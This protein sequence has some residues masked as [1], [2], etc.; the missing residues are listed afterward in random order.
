[1]NSFVE[2]CI[3]QVKP[4]KVG[5]FE[6]LVREMEVFQKEF[7]GTIDIKYMKRTHTLDGTE[8]LKTGEP[9]KKLERIIKSVKYV[10][11]WELRDCIVHGNATMK[12]FQRYGKDFNRLLVMPAD[13]LVGDKI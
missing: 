13:K 12:L 9:A 1:M 5:E 3:F 11:Y 2:V 10:F 8:V 6:N 4:D 7:D